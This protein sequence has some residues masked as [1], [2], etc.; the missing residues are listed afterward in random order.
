MREPKQITILGIVA[1]ALMLFLDKKDSLWQNI[2]NP[3]Y[4]LLIINFI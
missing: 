2:F 3:R 4:F 1:L